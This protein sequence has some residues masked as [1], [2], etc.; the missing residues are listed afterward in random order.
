MN[1]FET[2]YPL[3]GIFGSI[4]GTI[5]TVFALLQYRSNIKIETIRKTQLSATLNRVSN[6]VPFR[7]EIERMVNGLEKKEMVSWAWRKYKGLSD[8]YIM[9][10]SHYLYFEK[11]FSYEDLRRLISSGVISCSWEEDIWRSLIANRRENS[12]VPVP[13][14]ILIR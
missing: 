12:K 3:I 2:Y 14:K 13:R 10:V 6:L 8:L 7:E 1:G 11:I 9:M 5:G 4:F